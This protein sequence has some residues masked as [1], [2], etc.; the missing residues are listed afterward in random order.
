MRDFIHVF[1]NIDHDL[2]GYLTIDNFKKNFSK[3]M[4]N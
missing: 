1:V 4:S 2:D 3:V